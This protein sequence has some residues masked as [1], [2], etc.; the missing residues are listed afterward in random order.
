MHDV[1]EDKNVTSDELL[2]IGFPK[3]IVD[4]I[5]ILSKPKSMDYKKYIDRLVSDAPID[6]LMVKLADLENNMD[7]TRIKNPT[8]KDWER[9]EK[10]YTPAYEK[11]LN[12]I[13]EME[14]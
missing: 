4:G 5:L 2:E 12:R 13:K 11:I 14:N 6:S 10:K 9:V 3:D 7:M 8:L 1:I